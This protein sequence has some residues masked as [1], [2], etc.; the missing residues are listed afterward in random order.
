MTCLHGYIARRGFINTFIIHTNMYFTKHICRRVFDK[1]GFTVILAH[2]N[3]SIAFVNSFGI[4]IDGTLPPFLL[5]HQVLQH[6]LR[7][8]FALLNIYISEHLLPL[9]RL[10]R[11]HLHHEHRPRGARG[12]YQRTNNS[13]H[14]DS[15]FGSHEKASRTKTPSLRRPERRPP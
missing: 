3:G 10:H 6:L 5:R 12:A 13:G 11:P 9:L 1:R 2:Y 7:W 4:N 8:A 15:L 14:E